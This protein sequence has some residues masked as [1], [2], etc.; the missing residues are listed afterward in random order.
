M[1]NKYEDFC[2]VCGEVV[3]ELEGLVEQVPREPGDRGW[4]PTKWIVRH[5]NCQ[6]HDSKRGGRIES[7]PS[8]DGDT[9]QQKGN[10]NRN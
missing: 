3:A 2:Y 10:G 1:K 7:V 6:P 9:N 4:G 5:P 8:P